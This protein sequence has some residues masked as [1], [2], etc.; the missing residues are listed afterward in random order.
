MTYLEFKQYCARYGFTSTFLCFI[1]YDNLQR[2]GYSGDTIYCIEC[3]LQ[4]GFTL[5]EALDYHI[6]KE[7]CN[8]GI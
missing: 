8:A 5:S 6:N 4:A 1:E 2:L 3:D 7:S